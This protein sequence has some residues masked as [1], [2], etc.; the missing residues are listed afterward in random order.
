MQ[1]LEDTVCGVGGFSSTE[2]SEKND[3]SEKKEV[4]DENERTG[5]KD[6]VVK[7]ETLKGSSDRTRTDR[8]KKKTEETSRLSQ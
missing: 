4:K 6:E 2:V 1:G 8:N 5:E 7:N 3:T